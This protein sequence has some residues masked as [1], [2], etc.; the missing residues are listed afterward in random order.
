MHHHIGDPRLSVIIRIDAEAG[1]TRIEVHGVVTAANVRALYVVA[2]RVA[3]KLPDHEIVIDLA[4]SRVSEPAIDELRERARLSLIY[5]G[6][7]A[8][9]TPCRLR[10]V[11]PLVVLKAR[12]HV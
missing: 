9:E 8:S 6:I 4:H 10:L 5:S 3:H 2:R 7:D 11:D 1:S 12:A